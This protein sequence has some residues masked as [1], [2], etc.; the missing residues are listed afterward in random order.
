MNEMVCEKWRE[1]MAMHFFGD[2]SNEEEIGLLAHLEGCVEC[3]ASA[4]EIADTFETLGY[5]DRVA[6]ESTAAV[7]PALLDRVLGD[8]YGAGVLQRRHR[9]VRV[10]A[11]AGVG[12]VAASLIVVGV[13][14]ARPTT[15]PVQRTVALRGASTVRASAVLVDETWG[16]KVDLHENG[17]PGGNV[18][19]VSMKTSSGTWWTAGTYRSVAGQP[20]D[21]T[22]AC[23]V[24]LSKITGIRVLN[25]AG[26][27]VLTSYGA[28]S[29]ASY[30]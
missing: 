9:R 14:S 8:L 21:A 7:P 11:L 30:E 28:A 17:L 25:G 1:A 27:T 13:F 4:V 2:L 6:V 23:A 29:S 15:L 19:T 26:G 3:R 5:V 18:Y 24:S 20:V 12:A 22:M 10:A 16:T